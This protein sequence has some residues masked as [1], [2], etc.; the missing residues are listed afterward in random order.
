MIAGPASQLSLGETE[1]IALK[2]ARGQ[3]LSWG[4]AEEA[5]YAAR[6]LSDQGL[7]GLSILLGQLDQRLTLQNPDAAPVMGGRLWSPAGPDALCPIVAGTALNDFGLL[8]EG[9]LH[10]CL[11]IGPLSTPALLL[12]FVGL[13][14]AFADTAFKIEWA[15]CRLTL[16]RSGICEV[17]D[18]AGILTQK[19]AALHITPCDPSAG[20]VFVKKRLATPKA[21]LDG[22]TLYAAKTYVPASGLSRRNAGALGSD[23]H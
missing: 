23:D 21:T 8:P 14:A 20:P 17:L 3:G 5:A 19:T 16:C 22:L 15:Q 12:P 4:M 7:D 6:W 1:A 13:V 10:N 9:P 2:A 11:S 18:G